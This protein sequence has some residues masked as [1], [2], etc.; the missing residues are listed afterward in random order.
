MKKDDEGAVRADARV[1]DRILGREDE[2]SEPLDPWSES[3]RLRQ[4]VGRTPSSAG[5]SQTSAQ[6]QSGGQ[7]TSILLEDILGG[8]PAAN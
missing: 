4:Q 5:A 7:P 1:L 8:G 6:Q 3:D 2:L